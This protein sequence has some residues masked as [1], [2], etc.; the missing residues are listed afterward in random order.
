[1]RPVIVR[2]LQDLWSIRE[3]KFTVLIVIGLLLALDQEMPRYLR[4]WVG[5]VT[6]IAIPLIWTR[7][8]AAQLAYWG[9][10]E[11]ALRINELLPPLFGTSVLMEA[12]ILLVVGRYHDAQEAV[13]KLAFDSKGEPRTNEFSLYLYAKALL[14]EGR[15]E[16]AEKL[17]R[18]AIQESSSGLLSFWAGGQSPGTTQGAGLCDRACPHVTEWHGAL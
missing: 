3:T 6:L 16:E 5:S 2:R 12:W 10:Y 8:V 9:K 7:F 14:D 13:S 15:S 18:A 17:F 4:F 1:M 11:W